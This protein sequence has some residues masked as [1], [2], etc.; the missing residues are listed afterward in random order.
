MTRVARTGP[1]AVSRALP[2]LPLT[3]A[4]ASPRPVPGARPERSPAAITNSVIMATTKALGTSVTAGCSRT[5]DRATLAAV[6]TRSTPSANRQ[7]RQRQRRAESPARFLPQPPDHGLALPGGQP[8]QQANRD[9]AGTVL[10]PA[11]QSG[12]IVRSAEKSS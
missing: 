6:R 11:V 5:I 12:H 2:T 1:E 3:A 8:W 4:S 7:L 10:N 9:P